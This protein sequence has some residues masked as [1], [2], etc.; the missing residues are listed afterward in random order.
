MTLIRSDCAFLMI[1]AKTL[2]LRSL[3]PKAI[4]LLEQ[5]QS[6]DTFKAAKP[7]FAGV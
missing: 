3:C 7:S 5:C 6:I 2:I 4:A 1:T